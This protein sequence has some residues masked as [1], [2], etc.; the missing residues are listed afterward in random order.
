MTDIRRIL[1]YFPAFFFFIGNF[2][3]KASD[4]MARFM[5]IWRD[6]YPV[7]FF[8]ILFDLYYLTFATGGIIIIYRWG[9]KS[10]SKREKKQADIIVAACLVSFILA[11]FCDTLLP[12]LGVK[13][14][15]LGI[16]AL[17]IALMGIRHAITKYKMMTLTS[18]TA[19]DYILKTINDPVFLIG[20]D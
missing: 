1:I 15:S 14:F 5:F 8:E 11:A 13:I 3:Y 18:K 19:N 4:V 2:R 17:F 12:L 7:N 16:L 20:N 6:T 9:K 10:K